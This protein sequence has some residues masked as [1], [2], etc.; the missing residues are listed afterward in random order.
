MVAFTVV[1]VLLSSVDLGLEKYQTRAPTERRTEAQMT[2]T[3]HQYSSLDEGGERGG[4]GG[5]TVGAEPG[6]GVGDEVRG[7]GVGDEVGAGAEARRREGERERRRKRGNVSPDR[8][9]L[10][11]FVSRFRVWSLLFLL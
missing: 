11:C 9:C 7:E 3:I 5:K 6:E 4:A 10:P 8:I 2:P 1:V